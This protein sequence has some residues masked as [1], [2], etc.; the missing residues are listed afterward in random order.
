MKIALATVKETSTEKVDDVVK[1]VNAM[2]GI[3]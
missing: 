1:L 2:G 3:V